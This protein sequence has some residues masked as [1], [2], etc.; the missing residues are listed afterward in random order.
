MTNRLR[1]MNKNGIKKKKYIITKK[2]A[3]VNEDDHAARFVFELNLMETNIR[4]IHG[5]NN[6]KR[7]IVHVE[8]EQSFG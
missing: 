4:S 1:W 8:H 7:V 2:R 3:H 5:V 6:F